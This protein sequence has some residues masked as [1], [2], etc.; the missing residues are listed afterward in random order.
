MNDVSWL[1]SWSAATGQCREEDTTSAARLHRQH[2]VIKT[3][4]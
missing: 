1:V 3:D 4:S 2:G